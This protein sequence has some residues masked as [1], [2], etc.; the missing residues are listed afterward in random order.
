MVKK[1]QHLLVGILESIRL[2]YIFIFFVDKKMLKK[3]TSIKLL[4]METEQ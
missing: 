2:K 4:G 1:K 3:K